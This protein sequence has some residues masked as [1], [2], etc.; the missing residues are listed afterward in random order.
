MNLAALQTF[1]AIVETRSLVRASEQLNVTQST[2]TARLKTLE[3]ELGQ[4]LIIRQKSGAM[5]TAS[6]QRLRRYAE[7]MTQLWAQARQETAL[8]DQ[9][10]E[11]CNLGCHPD[12]WAGLGRDFF[13]LVRK[14]QPHAALSVW[15]GTAKEMDDWL[16]MG[17]VDVALTYAPSVR[18]PQQVHALGTDRLVLV[19]SR[20][21]ASA[22]ADPDYV[23]VEA[24]DPFGREHATV[25]ADTPATRLS[26]GSAVLGLEHILRAGG[27]AYLPER[28]A[29]PYVHRG[30]LFQIDAQVF[31]RPLFLVANTAAVQDWPWFDDA[32]EQLKR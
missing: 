22:A 8:P 13:D 20:A 5:L 2:V 1:L 28:I 26:F 4:T 16:E 3:E 25:Y 7:A 9:T 32:V 23:F 30:R 17:L 10:D 24:G 29:A 14:T 18:G 6:G 21:Q 12:L 15:T 31:D 19:A 27:S 11:I